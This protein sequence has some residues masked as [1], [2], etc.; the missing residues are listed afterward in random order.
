MYFYNPAIDQSVFVLHADGMDNGNPV[1]GKQG[2]DL[3]EIAGISQRPDVFQNADKY[4]L[5]ETTCLVPIVTRVKIDMAIQLGCGN[6]LQA[7][8]N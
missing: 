5:V 6:V 3:C 7:W 4:D 1:I 2:P 8:R